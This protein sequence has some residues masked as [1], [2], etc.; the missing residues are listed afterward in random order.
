MPPSV[1]SCHCLIAPE[2]VNVAESMVIG[3]MQ[4]KYIGSVPDGFYNPINSPIKT[5]CA[6]KKKA[7]VNVRPVIDLEN[8]FLL[9]LTLLLPMMLYQIT[10]Q[11]PRL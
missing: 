4:S 5:M 2:D 1:L 6:L 7:K 9:L 11:L 8:I 3:K 10:L